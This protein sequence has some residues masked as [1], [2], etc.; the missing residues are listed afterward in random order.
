MSDCAGYK[1]HRTIRS[2]SRGLA[3]VGARE[4]T[5]EGTQPGY[6]FLCPL[7]PNPHAYMAMPKKK[8]PGCALHPHPAPHNG[9]SPR[10]QGSPPRACGANCTYEK[11]SLSGTS[12]IRCPFTQAS[13]SPAISPRR[14]EAGAIVE[15]GRA[16]TWPHC[17][18][19]LIGDGVLGQGK[20]R[21]TGSDLSGERSAVV[22]ILRYF[23]V[24]R[25]LHAKGND[26]SGT[27][28]ERPV[29][30]PVLSTPPNT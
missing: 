15:K 12:P 11:F 2:P 21:E 23:K 28:T 30:D 16:G 3:E 5:I 26:Q 1:A 18:G 20:N 9:K 22:D 10:V 25:P 14:P 29:G 13:G 19:A 7:S 27:G 8:A 17:P 24:Q 6:S 4:A